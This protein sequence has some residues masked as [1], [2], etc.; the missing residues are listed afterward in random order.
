ME[1]EKNDNSR[2]YILLIIL[3]VVSLIVSYFNYKLNYIIVIPTF[4]N[5]TYKNIQKHIQILKNVKKFT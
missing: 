3:S 1:K 5:S 4:D 2:F